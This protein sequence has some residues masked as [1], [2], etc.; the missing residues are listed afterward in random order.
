DRERL[1]VHIFHITEYEGEPIESEEMKPEWF[2][3]D[4][5]PFM[6]MW[7]DDKYWF[8]L[9]L[10]DRKFIGRFLF[11]DS[12]NILEQELREMQSLNI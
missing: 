1:E 12:D 10:K 2:H 9:F 5:I 7:P 6:E 8:P 11:D 4:E 3:I